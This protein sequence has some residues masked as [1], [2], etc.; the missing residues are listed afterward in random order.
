MKK[1]TV[2][3]AGSWGIA[4]AVMLDRNGYEVSLWEYFED[5]CRKIQ[6]LREQPDKLPGIKIPN[7]IEITNDRKAAVGGTSGIV[8]A[9]PSHV[10]RQTVRL[11]SG[12]LGDKVELIVNLAKGI[13]NNTLCRMSEVLLQELPVNYHKRIITLSGPSHAE[14]VSR[15]MP[16]TVVAAAENLEVAEKTQEI[17]ANNSFRVYTS[18]DLIGVELGG[19][20]KN[21]IAIAGGIV[22]GLG[23]GD[24]TMGALLTR[25]LAEIVRLGVKMGA[26]PMT[27]AGLSGVGDLIT[28]CFSRHSRNRH[29]GEQLGKGR[30]IDEILSSMK[31]IAEGVKTTQSAY[32]LAQKYEVDMPITAEV[33]NIIFQA[34]NPR[35]ALE[36]LMSRS[37]KPEIWM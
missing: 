14:E 33:Y 7:R 37:P 23:L 34:K 28:T 31:M 25:G 35:V 12:L 8:L 10:M 11:F 16:T 17:F 3:G 1:I 15:E 9:L 29:V 20:L 24:N 19:S 21:V 2:L 32:H 27:F 5:D 6:K 13:E 18:T 4:V 36:D 26:D 30:N 22:Q